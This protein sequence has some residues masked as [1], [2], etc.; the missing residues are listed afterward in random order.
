MGYIVVG[1]D[2]SEPARRALAWAAEEAELRGDSLVVVAAWEVPASALMATT[3]AQPIE[4]DLGADAEARAVEVLQSVETT[5]TVAVRKVAAEGHPTAVLM[6]EAAGADLLVLGA[7]GHREITGLL[8]GSVA[9][10]AVTH[11][12]CPVVVVRGG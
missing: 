1:L 10:H 12:P 2:G 8:L 6:R 3:D 11:A 5:P 7:S 9:L 4:L